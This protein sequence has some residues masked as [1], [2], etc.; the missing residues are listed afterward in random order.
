MIL[1]Y[2]N[3][4]RQTTTSGGCDKYISMKTI[5]LLLLTTIT[6][7]AQTRIYHKDGGSVEGK[8][9]EANETHVIFQRAED[10]QQFL[11]ETIA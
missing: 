2:K 8:I 3:L 10:L 1:N 5:A 6:A 4:N 9:L 11:L 7:F